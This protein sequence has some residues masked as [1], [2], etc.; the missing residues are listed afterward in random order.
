M[1]EEKEDVTQ[2]TPEEQPEKKSKKG[3]YAAL[4]GAQLVIAAVLAWYFIFPEYQ[5]LAEAKALTEGTEAQEAEEHE[6]RELGQIYSI[7]NITVNPKGSGGTRFAVFELALEVMEE[8]DLESIQKYEMVLM[9]NYIN[10][11]RSRT[12]NELTDETF[13]DSMKEDLKVLANDILGRDA[14]SR[15]YFTRFVLE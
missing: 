1:A 15:V 13:T 8:G 14:V 11:F 10:Y 12:V 7:Q 9:D 6:P 5:Q 3:L 4:I 2:E